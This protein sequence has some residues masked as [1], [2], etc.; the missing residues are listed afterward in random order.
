[1]RREARPGDSKNE[2]KSGNEVK[3]GRA[4]LLF[5]RAGGGFFKNFRGDLGPPEGRGQVVSRLVRH[6]RMSLKNR[7]GLAFARNE[8]PKAR[9]GF[10]RARVSRPE[11]AVANF[12]HPARILISRFTKARTVVIL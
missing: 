6:A 2:S 10:L 3:E 11:S 9:A 7:A 1:V 8:S 5:P 4:A 12:S